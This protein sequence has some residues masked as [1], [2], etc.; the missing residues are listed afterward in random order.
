MDWKKIKRWNRNIHRDLGFFISAL[1]IAYCISGLALNHSDSWNADFILQKDTISIPVE[2]T[3]VNLNNREAVL[4]LC[5]LVGEDSY[6]VFDFPTADQVKIYFD[7]ASFH[8]NMKEGK[9][10]YEKIQRRPLIYQTNLLHRNSIK[11]WKWVADVFAILLI[12]INLT[13]LFILK[14]KYGITGRGLWLMLLGFLPALIALILA[15]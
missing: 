14:G 12:G 9:G 6:K 11:H 8:V 4:K 3:S 13:G 5:A 2:I 10:L 7:K 15:G 1:L